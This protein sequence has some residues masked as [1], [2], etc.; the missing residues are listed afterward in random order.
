MLVVYHLLGKTG[1]STVAVNGTGQI[2][3]G[4]FHGYALVPFTSFL[5]R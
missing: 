1:W 5:G 4:N 3:K 2:P